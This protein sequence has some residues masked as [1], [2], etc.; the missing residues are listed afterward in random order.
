MITYFGGVEAPGE[1]AITVARGHA[2]LRNL[3]AR[4][5]TD[6][7]PLTPS[8]LFLMFIRV[9]GAETAPRHFCKGQVVDV[10]AT[11]LAPRHFPT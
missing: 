6:A 8:G 9:L 11:G 3:R 10:P 5:E 7:I 2:L 4:L 1:R